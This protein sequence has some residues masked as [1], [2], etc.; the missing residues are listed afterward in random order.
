MQDSA[1]YNPDFDVIRKD[2]TRLQSDMAD[3][4]GHL[5]GNSEDRSTAIRKRVKN[6][7]ERALTY[8]EDTIRERPIISVMAMFFVGVIMGWLLDRKLTK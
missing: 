1:E 8:S 4:L 5:S 6:T 7:S 3:L 2:I